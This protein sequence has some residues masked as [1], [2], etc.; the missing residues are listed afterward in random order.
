MLEKKKTSV[1]HGDFHA[2]N[3]FVEG[4]GNVYI[5]DYENVQIG[6]PEVELAYMMSQIDILVKPYPQLGALIDNMANDIIKD[7][8]LYATIRGIFD[9]GI[10]LNKRFF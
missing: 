6:I 4:K 10:R 9:K 2:N 5:L 1:I 3:V 7:K 8:I